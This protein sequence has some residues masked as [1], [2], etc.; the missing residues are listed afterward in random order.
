[1]AGGSILAIDQGTTSTRAMVF[2]QNAHVL[3]VAQ[4][5]LPQIFPADGWVEHDP[6]EIWSATLAVC[7]EV[8]AKVPDVAAIGITNQRETTVLWD[9]KTGKPLHNAIVW[10]DR[11]GAAL[12]QKLEQ[13]GHGAMVQKVTGLLLDPYFSASK[14]AWL[15]ENVAGAKQKAEAGDLAIGTIDTFLLWRLTGGKVHA[16]DATNA[17]RT[18]LF[19]IHRQDW[20]EE[21]LAL[22]GV[23][24][25]LLPEVRD[26]SADYGATEASLFGRAIP[27]AG[28][29][30]DQQAAAVGQACFSPGMIKSTYGTGCFVLSNTGEKSP[31]SKNRLVT[32][33][34]LR[35]SGKVT[36]AVEGS[37]FIA[38]AGVQWIRDGL[39]LVQNAGETEAMAASLPGNAGVYLV[40]AFTGLGAPYWDP[41]ARGAI[42]GLTR[43][44]GRPQIARAML[45]AVCYQT[46]DLMEAMAA[47]GTPKPT[48]LRVDGG[49]TRN[50]WLMQFLA[51]MLDIPVERPVVTETTALGAAYLAGLKAGLWSS[52]GD[53]ASHWQRDH[54]FEPAMKAAER[55]KLYAGW[56]DAV[57]RVRR[58]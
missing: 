42:F 35:L 51:D 31:V 1:M 29:A 6:E 50:N 56:K 24:R 39:G 48:S 12:C 38:G 54:L 23:S 52:T 28:I 7:R 36:Y 37:I 49:M 20:S 9:R 32:T 17:S 43:D 47:D 11:R 13:A 33:V 44:V 55:D 14:I 25:K 41:A 21:L 3:A 57:Q 4:K 58:S 22:F 10:Q 2:D 30:G 16:S 26:C 5:E 27:I 53:I 8:L 18:M 19:D 34:A 15:M 45:E 46:R 40:P